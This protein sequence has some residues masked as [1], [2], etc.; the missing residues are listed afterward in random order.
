MGMKKI[1]I[2]RGILQ[3]SDDKIFV[4]SPEYHYPVNINS[5]FEREYKND[6]TLLGVVVNDKFNICNQFNLNT[7]KN[8]FGFIVNNG[9]ESTAVRVKLITGFNQHTFDPYNSGY[10]LGKEIVLQKDYIKNFY[11]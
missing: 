8:Y 6:E 2:E 11:E 4:Y 1:K 3:I 10:S 5:L 9:F 7:G